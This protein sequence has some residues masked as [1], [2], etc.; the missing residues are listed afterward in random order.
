MR[1]SLPPPEK[2]PNGGEG[3]FSSLEELAASIGHELRNPLGVIDATV[4]LL[5]KRIGADPE[6]APHLDRIE[7]QVRISSRIIEDLLALAKDQP[8]RAEAIEI[9]EVLGEACDAVPRVEG[10]SLSLQLSPHLPKVRADQG[11]LRQ[12]LVNLL[13]NARDAVGEAGEIRISVRPEE[14]ALA[15]RISDSGPGIQP[16]LRDQIFE[17]MVTTKERGFGLG[18]ALCRRLLERMGGSVEL[19]EGELDGAT[20]VI[21]LPAAPR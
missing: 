4:F 1:E 15:I 3:G 16:E 2:A 17:P 18:L 10:V 9:E 11:L 7:E 20:F 14:E 8:V 19:G 21:Q 12:V 6:L 5:R 13:T